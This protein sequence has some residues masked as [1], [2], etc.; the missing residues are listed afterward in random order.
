MLPLV[1]GKR[2]AGQMVDF[3]SAD[4]AHQVVGVDPPASS[5]STCRSL[6]QHRLVAAASSCN[7]RRISPAPLG[8]STSP[9][10]RARM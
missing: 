8:E 5:G 9:F 7:A 2:D 1:A 4:D 6:L 3:Q 10:S